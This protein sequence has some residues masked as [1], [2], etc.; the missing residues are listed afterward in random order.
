MEAPRALLYLSFLCPFLLSPENKSKKYWSLKLI[1]INLHTE[2][3]S[4]S[5]RMAFEDDW[6]TNNY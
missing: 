2:S 1:F 6:E 3:G 5:I 4:Y